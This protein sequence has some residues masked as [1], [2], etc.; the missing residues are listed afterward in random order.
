MN[1]YTG[2]PG[3]LVGIPIDARETDDDFINTVL[4]VRQSLSHDTSFKDLLFQVRSNLVEIGE[5]QNYPVDSLPYD[6]DLQVT[7]DYFPLFDVA[8]L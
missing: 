5:Y 4:T 2:N 8:V 3:I 6:L 7:G 1:K